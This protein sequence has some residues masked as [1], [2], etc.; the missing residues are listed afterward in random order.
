VASARV[1]WFRR[2]VEIWNSGDVEAF[3][4][5]LGPDFTFRP[6]PSFPDAGTY[7]GEDWR[8]WL[9]EWART[10]GESRLEVLG[11]PTEIGSALI[12]EA[13]WHL[14]AASTGKAIPLRDFHFVV[15]FDGERAV[16][17]AAF[18]DRDQADEAAREPTG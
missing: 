4:D 7:R 17:A 16:R 9:G 14:T 6:D 12:V 8:R 15:W 11:T 2:I 18:F 13:R 1:E 5:E 3:L 10:W